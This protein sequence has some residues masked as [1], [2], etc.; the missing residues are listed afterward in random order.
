MASRL[1]E[2]MP[3]PVCGSLSHPKVAELSSE[4]PHEEELKKAKMSCERAYENV[5]EKAKQANIYHTKATEAASHLE[6]E[7]SQLFGKVTDADEQI[8][9]L[10]KETKEKLLKRQNE[11]SE[12]EKRIQRKVWL[13]K[14]FRKV[15]LLM[16]KKNKAGKNLWH[17]RS[18]RRKHLKMR[19]NKSRK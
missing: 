14:K 4:V 12:E 18:R 6:E 19:R 5:N 8:A 15:K 17:L 3:C 7:L 13:E 10:E 2:D 16:R 1:V 9:A 11:L